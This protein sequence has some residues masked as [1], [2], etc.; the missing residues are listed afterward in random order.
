MN[1]ENTFWWLLQVQFPDRHGKQQN[2][3][4][5]PIPRNELLRQA[6]SL[7]P[8]KIRY[9]RGGATWGFADLTKIDDNLYTFH[10]IVKPP[11]AQ[12]A[13]EPEP[14]HLEDSI[15]PRYYTLCVVNIDRQIIMLHKSS[16]ISRYARSAKTFSY[17]IQD[18][19]L[20]AV[21]DLNMSEHYLVEVDPIAKTGSFVEWFS[22]LDKLK[23][24][25]IKHTG[26]NLPS[27]ADD[28]ITD[29]KESAKKYKNALRS[30]DVE[31]V[32]NEPDIN[33]EEVEELD[34][35]VADRRLKLTA[36]GVR[37]GVG[38]TWKSSKKP[39]PETAIMPIKE[40]QLKDKQMVASRINDY[41][42]N[43]YEDR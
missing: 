2:L 42:K 13:A 28:L 24:I 31:L 5:N 34:K 11:D 14:G 20:K 12:I 9:T 1:F 38:T 41:L 19:L 17:I 26:S 36:R 8:S 37:S 35:A 4:S 22:G 30:R 6:V 10:L 27:G 15:D 7:I 32:A 33:E 29:I 43:Y 23:R 3:F 39:I 21:L 16:D 40:E 18:L 25:T